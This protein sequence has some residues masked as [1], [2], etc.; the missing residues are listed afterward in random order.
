LA[1]GVDNSTDKQSQNKDKPSDND[2]VQVKSKQDKLWY[3]YSHSPVHVLWITTSIAL[4]IALY[5]AYLEAVSP[6]S[7]LD[8]VL[9]RSH[10]NVTETGNAT[11]I[12]KII[13]EKIHAPFVPRFVLFW[14]FIGAATYLLKVTTFKLTQKKG[15][16][17]KK[18]PNI[19]RGCSLA[20]HWP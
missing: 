9:P 10:Y 1:S 4:I 14:G 13:P 18:S 6:A 20:P 3:R 19:S 16:D 17:E 12:T 11:E 8:V 5:F 2:K 7:V 15:F